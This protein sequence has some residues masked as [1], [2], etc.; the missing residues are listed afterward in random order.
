[1]YED[2]VTFEHVLVYLQQN[3]FVLLH[4]PIELLELHQDLVVDNHLLS[5][6]LMLLGDVL[7]VSLTLRVLPRKQMVDQLVSL[8][9]HE[10]VEEVLALRWVGPVDP[11]PIEVVQT[12]EVVLAFLLLLVDR[13]V[14]VLQVALRQVL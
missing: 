1:L 7:V 13:V 5:L 11:L 4:L 10:S 14:E 9:T 8:R 2:L 6:Q 3:R 12:H